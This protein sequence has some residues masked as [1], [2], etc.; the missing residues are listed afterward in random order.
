MNYVN[1]VF[2]SSIDI[3]RVS[4]VGSLTLH[5][6]DVLFYNEVVMLLIIEDL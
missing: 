5:G 3:G 4:P 1:F 6:L 2:I